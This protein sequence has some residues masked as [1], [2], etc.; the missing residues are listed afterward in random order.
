MSKKVTKAESAPV[1]DQESGGFLDQN[2]DERLKEARAQR[3]KNLSEKRK[4]ERNQVDEEKDEEAGA[5]LL[6]AVGAKALFLF[7]GSAGLALGVVLGIG[8][9]IGWG[10]VNQTKTASIMAFTSSEA[11]EHVPAIEPVYDVAKLDPPLIADDVEVVEKAENVEEP[12]MPSTSITEDVTLVAAVERDPV[13]DTVTAVQTESVAPAA[14]TDQAPVLTVIQ[15]PYMAA[16]PLEVETVALNNMPEDVTLF[17]DRLFSSLS[18]KKRSLPIVE[19]EPEFASPDPVNVAQVFIHAPNGVSDSS[20]ENFSSQV[21][22]AGAEVAGIGRERFRVS[23]THLRYYSPE[24]AD[25]ANALAADLGLTA[26]DFSQNA[27]VPG[28]IELW[29]AGPSKKRTV[30][31]SAYKKPR[32][33]LFSSSRSGQEPTYFDL[34]NR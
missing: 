22:S 11:E 3:A 14:V 9:L 6:P 13:V 18:S 2:W 12:E 28:R 25:A 32:R 21:E 27:V 33:K 5:F 16:A 34:G 30:R 15:S 7:A 20:L 10:Q 31:R 26:R 24:T 19:A 29:V 23:T 17:S 1:A 4:V 8:I